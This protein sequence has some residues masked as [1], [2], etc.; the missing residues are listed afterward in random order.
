MLVYVVMLVWG[1]GCHSP[2]A[3]EP[4]YLA[5]GI[6]HWQYN[7]FELCKVSPPL[8]RLVAAIPVM[9]SGARVDLSLVPNAPR[10]EHVAGQVF[11]KA[12][13]ENVF[14]LFTIGRWACIP[15][16]LLGAWVC[17]RW[18]TR[19]YGA[20]AG[21]AGLLL[22]CLSPN[23][24][25]HSQMLNADV[26]VTS[27]SL[28]ACY[29]FWQWS[30]ECDF[31]TVI[32]AG[33]VLGLAILAKTNALVIPPA[34]LTAALIYGIWL[35]DGLHTKRCIH[36]LVAFFISLVVINAGYG[37][38]GT[39]KK[40]NEFRF[41]SKSFTG[42]ASTSGSYAFSGSH[43][44]NFPVPLPAT[45]VEGIDLQKYDFENAHGG[46]KT[47]FRGS[48]YSHSWWWYY[49]YVVAI[50]V[51]L[52]T[53]VL[54]IAGSVLLASGAVPNRVQV[55]CFV[56]LPGIGLFLPACFQTG[57]GAGVRYVLPAFPFAFL[58]G[59]AAFYRG[60]SHRVRWLAAFALVLGPVASLYTFPHSLCY[61]NL[62]GGGPNNGHFHLIDSN[63][64][65][66]QN[67]L[68]V[69]D[70]LE[71]NKHKEKGPIYVAQ[72]SFYP[73]DGLGLDFTEPQV[74]ATGPIPP[75]TYLISTNFLRGNAHMNRMELRRFLELVPDER[76]AYTTY[77]YRIP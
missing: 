10:S 22:W 44:D 40:L 68:Y 9:L 55:L 12:Y 45:F 46:F 23:I 14:W 29:L 21:L 49:L 59:S 53:W 30:D 1:G 51:P 3:D 16:A 8:V 4:A 36:L 58:V 50:K 26:G 71:E 47:Y 20:H 11:L 67:L 35:R 43:L 38:S 41:V 61:F 64:E 72:W 65:W 37:F 48:W 17:Y 76:I 15:F 5:S 13:G 66:G 60:I 56:V 42:D 31:L 62:L 34:V 33:C 6:S 2:I 28:A 18:A 75:G 27:L 73:L 57:F 54:V 70:W 74:S 19:L 77:V 32:G 7:Q 63:M 52:G 25:A 39:F 69:R 24:L